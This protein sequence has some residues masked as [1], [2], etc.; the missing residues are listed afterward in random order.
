[1]KQNKFTRKGKIELDCGEHHDSEPH[2]TLPLFKDRS[3]HNLRPRTVTQDDGTGQRMDESS[4]ANS[5]M[6]V[7]LGEM[8]LPKEA[9]E[10]LLKDKDE[11]ISKLRNQVTGLTEKNESLLNEMYELRHNYNKL[12][13]K[14]RPSQVSSGCEDPR[15]SPEKKKHDHS[16][17]VN[18]GMTKEATF[19]SWKTGSFNKSEKKLC[20]S[21]SMKEKCKDLTALVN[22]FSSGSKAAEKHALKRPTNAMLTPKGCQKISLH[23]KSNLLP[24]SQAA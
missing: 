15:P 14:V 9:Y 23:L 4:K 21:I 24:H 1:M 19:E 7:Q 11:T 17:V 8:E 5:N 3:E 16:R 18:T 22:K 2:V 20:K 10:R 12:L 13:L 6:S